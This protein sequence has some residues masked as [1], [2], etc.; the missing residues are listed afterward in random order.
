MHSYRGFDNSV[1]RAMDCRISVK[2]KND[3]SVAQMEMTQIPPKGV[4][5]EV[6]EKQN[7]NNKKEM[8]KV[9]AHPQPAENTNKT[10]KTPK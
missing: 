9:V 7:K 5:S 6:K 2:R 8:V 4:N 10:L 3:L 1:G